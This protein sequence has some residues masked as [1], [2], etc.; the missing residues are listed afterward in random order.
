[1]ANFPESWRLPLADLI[2]RLVTWLIA[3]FGPGFDAL[4]G[5]VSFLLLEMEQFLLGLPWQ[6]VTAAVALAGW[7]VT[8]RWHQGVTLGLLTF[9]I[10]LFGLWDEAMRTLAIV[11]LSVILAAGFGIP[12]GVAAAANRTVSA[13]LRPVLDGMQTMPIFVYLVPAMMFFGMGKVPA[14]FATVL[15][16]MP[17][18]IRLTDLGI[19]QVSPQA[20]EA[21]RAFGGTRWQILREVQL[22]LALPSIMAGVNQTTMMAL[23]MVVTASMIGARGLGLEVLRSIQRIEVGRS[24]EAGLA[25]VFLA[26]ALDRILQG[27]SKARGGAH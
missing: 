26:V 14:L 1:M 8:R 21:A 4:A 5:A 19:R 23:S 11:L 17:P 22:P 7:G 6:V 24:F 12:L 3:Q 10:G 13:A 27:L 20:V 2:D 16:A 9:A 18:S 15:F 25:I